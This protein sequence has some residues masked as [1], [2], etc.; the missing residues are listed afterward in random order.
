MSAD[1]EIIELGD[2]GSFDISTKPVRQL[3]PVISEVVPDNDENVV[4]P[5]VFETLQAG[6]F[7]L[8]KRDN[9]FVLVVRL[10]ASD[11]CS[12]V[13]VQSNNEIVVEGISGQAYN[14][15][16]PKEY[17]LNVKNSKT[18]TSADFVLIDME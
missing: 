12:K 18:I 16:V 1:D 15:K 9:K 8:M 2:D 3:V 6:Q 4:I 7:S 5:S 10:N 14:C 17:N 13:F 11:E